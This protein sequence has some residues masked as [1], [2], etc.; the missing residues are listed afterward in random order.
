MTD[1]YLGFTGMSDD[2]D[3]KLFL[4]GLTGATPQLS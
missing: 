4:Q 1:V 3:A 2:P